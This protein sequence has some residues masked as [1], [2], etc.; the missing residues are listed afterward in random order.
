MRIR[1]LVVCMRCER[2][3]RKSRWIEN[4]FVPEHESERRRCHEC[5]GTLTISEF[6]PEMKQGDA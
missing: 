3:E 5:K 2:A 4:A 6:K 1:L